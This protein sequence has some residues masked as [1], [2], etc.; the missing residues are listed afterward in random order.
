M[1]TRIDSL[2]ILDRE[3]QYR[4]LSGEELADRL[5]EMLSLRLSGRAALPTALRRRLWLALR[6]C[7]RWLLVQTLAINADPRA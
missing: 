7:P 6:G 4:D 3:G 5:A 2:A 1:A